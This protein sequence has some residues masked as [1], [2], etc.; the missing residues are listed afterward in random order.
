MRVKNQEPDSFVGPSKRTRNCNLTKF[1]TMLLEEEFNANKCPTRK[2]LA[3]IAFDLEMSETRVT[4]WFINRMK[5]ENGQFVDDSVDRIGW[6]DFRIICNV[7][8]YDM[9][10][11]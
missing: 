1:Q 8:R 3:D 9:E 4:N 2:K 7:I 11:Y 10:R 6:H 5:K